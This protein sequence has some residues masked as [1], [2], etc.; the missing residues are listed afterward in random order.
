M[1][2]VFFKRTEGYDFERLCLHAGWLLDVLNLGNLSGRRVLIKPDFL[3]LATPEQAVTTHPTLLKAVCA[4]FLDHNAKVTV[5][6]RH[7]SGRFSRFL[8]IGGYRDALAGMPVSVDTFKRAVMVEFGEPFGKINLPREVVEAELFVNVPKL[9][10]HCRVGLNGCVSNIFD[11]ITLREKRHCYLAVNGDIKQMAGLMA[12][13]TH[14]LMPEVNIMDGIMGL[15]GQGPGVHGKP[16]DY[17]ILVTGN[18]AF[19]VDSALGRYIG[20]TRRQLPI[21]EQAM[22]MGLFDP[23]NQEIVG[24]FYTMTNV[25]LPP[26]RR[27]FPVPEKFAQKAKKFWYQR[28]E[29]KGACDLCGACSKVCPP[30]IIKFDKSARKI[31]IDPLKCIRCYSCVAA[32]PKGALTVENPTRGKMAQRKYDKRA[33]VKT[34][35]EIEYNN[36]KF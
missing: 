5:R 23:Y 31:I 32:C 28:V 2:V 35:K 25:D 1:G 16:E 15:H 11:C 22:Q 10:T 26:K 3:Y 14:T 34:L 19:S 36:G 9:K 17:S 18:N 27:D 4:Y 33:K 29:Q 21:I 30:E 20:M 24:E 6:S 13:I 8:Q 7:L 12:K